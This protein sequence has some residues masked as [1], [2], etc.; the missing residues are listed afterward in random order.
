M[1]NSN[2]AGAAAINRVLMDAVRDERFDLLRKGVKAQLKKA[3]EGDLNSLAWIFDRIV[4]RAVSQV[5]VGAA[6][7][8]EIDLASIMRLVMQARSA[9]ADDAQLIENSAESQPDPPTP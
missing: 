6:D 7:A 5:E 2:R 3:S 8:R 1:G 4:G 9:S